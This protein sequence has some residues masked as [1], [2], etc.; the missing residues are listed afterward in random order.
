[1]N[2]LSPEDRKLLLEALKEYV[3]LGGET[4]LGGYLD[5]D[6]IADWTDPEERERG[7]RYRRSSVRLYLR[8]IDE[9]ADA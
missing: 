1:M 6:G 7:M 9:W 2:E 3:T 8:L 4:N 5:G